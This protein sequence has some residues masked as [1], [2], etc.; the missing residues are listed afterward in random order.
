M[1]EDAL[2]YAEMG[3]Y[4]FPCHTPLTKEGWSCSCEA[5]RRKKYPDYNCTSPGKHPRTQHGLDDATLDHEQIREWWQ[6]WP[7]ANIGI[8]CGLSGLLVIDLDQYKDIYQGHDLDLDEDTV[9]AITG[10]GGCHLF[11]QLE[12]GDQFGNRNKEL[13]PGI[14]IR[15]HGGYV[16]VAPS[17]HS[18]GNCYQWELEYTPFDTEIKPIPP[19]LREILTAGRTRT[20]STVLF[21]TSPKYNGDGI[22]SYGKVALSAEYEKVATAA[23]GTRNNTL[24]DSAF[25]IGRLVAGGEIDYTVAF[26]QLKGA[27][28]DAGLSD[29]EAEQTTESGMA[30]GMEHPRSSKPL[31]EAESSVEETMAVMECPDPALLKGQKAQDAKPF[32]LSE[33]RPEDGGILDLWYD[34][35]GKNRIFAVGFDDWFFW[36]N[37]HW[38]KDQ[39]LSIVR[40]IEQLM[41]TM[42]QIARQELEFAIE[43]EDKKLWGK[44]VS[45]TQRSRNRVASVEGMAQARC[46]V[47]SSMLNNGNVLNLSNG[48]LD[49]DTLELRK[50][51]Q[52]DYL[53]HCLPYAYDASAECPRYEK[54]LGEVLVKDGTTETDHELV[55]LYQEAQGY[56]LTTD[57]RY[58]AMFWFSGDGGNGK[59]VAI[60][61]LQRLLGP[62]CFSVA[63]EEMGKSNNYDLAEVAG[64]RV[65]F[66]TESERG[67][68]LAEGHIKRIVSGE[69]INARPIYGSPFE[70]TST[71]K[72]F[73]AMNDL[74]VIKD[75]SNGVWRRLKL[76]PFLRTFT[77]KDK[78][79]NLIPE[80][81]K[82]LSG[83]LNHA[84]TGLRSLRQRGH[85]PESAAVK[86]A[87]EEYRHENNPIQQWLDER[88]QPTYTPGYAPSVYATTAK[89]LFDDY[90][91]WAE[92]NGRQTMNSTNF[93]R[94]MGRLKIPKTKDVR[95]NAY[96]LIIVES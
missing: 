9:T 67:G 73:W 93:G 86:A 69:R 13:P 2:R 26:A 11:Y 43:K 59:T 25:A 33:Y 65:I 30:A 75:T 10:G 36:N 78:N 40:E 89:A 23:S 44:Y 56:A 57:T 87:V 52:T 27:A 37:T 74:P 45:A 5:W 47:P 82:E 7:H 38:T 20:T 79:P 71:A 58:E 24:N 32:D 81:E 14:D 64:K 80:L 3:W 68:K 1:I 22:S 54:F 95:G 66:S 83:I 39:Q 61:M 77:E 96:A 70:F 21:D 51:T 49:L 31:D 92:Q 41:D 46:A 42:N 12:E 53:T 88:T 84:L 72:V 62:L 85:F 50:H 15:G 34:L 8:N 6:R 55:A 94:E 19:K 90:K 48:T 63:F 18:S 4:V 17:L 28:M 76:I 91:M 60:T 35:H 29:E 16:V